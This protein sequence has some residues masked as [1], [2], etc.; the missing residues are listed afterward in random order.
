MQD[1]IIASGYPAMEECGG[2]DAACPV[3]MTGNPEADPM[4]APDVQMW[5]GKWPHLLAVLIISRSASITLC[6]RV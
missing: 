6:L 3:S 2:Y 1:P 4:S 5:A